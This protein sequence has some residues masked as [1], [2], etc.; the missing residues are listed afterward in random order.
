MATWKPIRLKTNK[1]DLRWILY[2]D[3]TNTKEINDCQNFAYRW[4]TSVF[5][6]ANDGRHITCGKAIFFLRMQVD[7]PYWS[8]YNWRIFA[9]FQVPNF[10]STHIDKASLYS[11][12]RRISLHCVEN[13]AWRQHS[14]HS[15]HR[16]PPESP[17]SQ[18]LQQ[19]RQPYAVERSRFS[20]RWA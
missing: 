17:A 19:D 6:P 8:E 11:I 7:P 18:K 16:S 13:V 9:M 5:S 15:A 12:T 20:W 4:E 2:T 14:P 3:I 10:V 1:Q